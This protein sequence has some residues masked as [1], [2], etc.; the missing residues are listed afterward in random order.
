MYKIRYSIGLK[1]LAV[2]LFTVSLAFTALSAT[3]I[4]YMASENVYLDGGRSLQ[5]HLWEVVLNREAARAA[6]H[7]YSHYKA[8]LRSDPSGEDAEEMLQTFQKTYAA[9][10]TN[11]LFS[12]DVKGETIFSNGIGRGNYA[13]TTFDDWF[14]ENNT[15]ANFQDF[16]TER[17]M[18]AFFEKNADSWNDWRTEIIY[19]EE[20]GYY[21]DDPIYR[22][23]YTIYDET[24]ESIQVSAWV[25]DIQVMDIFYWIN[26]LS[27]SVSGMRWGLIVLGVLSLA[28]CVASLVFLF[29][30]AGRKSTV[31]G[32]VLSGLNRIPFDLYF[33]AVIFCWS[34]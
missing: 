30:G 5:K 22:L 3:G 34:I 28:I 25:D 10:E 33:A 29:C 26:T 24:R 4:I 13:A 2:F 7:V 27:D 19:E 17:E 9:D 23:H 32:V 14:Y 20:D 12:I 18:N 31:E 1:I 6:D 16:N 21:S 8:A 15:T 11:M